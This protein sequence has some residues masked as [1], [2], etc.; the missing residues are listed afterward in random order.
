V[1]HEEPASVTLIRGGQGLTLE[2]S[3][4]LACLRAEAPV[5]VALA[6]VIEE[7][8]GRLSHWALEHPSGRPDFHHRDGFV[9]Q[10]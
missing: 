9:L 4:R 8:S 3:I 6:A 10:I 2:A 5:K 1:D 7:S